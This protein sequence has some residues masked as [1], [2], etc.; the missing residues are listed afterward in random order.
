MT[1]QTTRLL[2]VIASAGI[3]I[4]LSAGLSPQNAAKA[5]VKEK[6]ARPLLSTRVEVFDV[7]ARP[8]CLITPAPYPDE[9]KPGCIYSFWNLSPEG[10]QVYLVGSARLCLC[11][12]QVF[13]F[14]KTMTAAEREVARAILAKIRAQH[15]ALSIHGVLNV[16]QLLTEGKLSPGD[17]I[18]VLESSHP[19]LG[20]ACTTDLSGNHYP[21]SL[22]TVELPLCG[23]VPH[24][25]RNANPPP[26]WIQE[27]QCC[28]VGIVMK[29]KG[30]ETQ[31]SRLA[32]QLLKLLGSQKHKPHPARRR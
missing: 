16:E 31:E 22:C 5:A 3:L 8:E 13:P 29:K 6:A 32:D 12:H 15:E 30:A 10:C 14:G 28:H 11:R 9:H 21:G 20:E 17:K 7:H 25:V 4:Q 24:A 2:P 26:F 27:N 23:C 18:V 19:H 1:R